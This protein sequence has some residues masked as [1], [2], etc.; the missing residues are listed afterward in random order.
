VSRTLRSSAE[1]LKTGAAF[2]KFCV[3]HA[4]TLMH[5]RR[6]ASKPRKRARLRSPILFRKALFSSR[7]RL[8][9]N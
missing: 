3:W 4:G 2:V 9:K 7:K 8:M 6:R 1:T 5:K